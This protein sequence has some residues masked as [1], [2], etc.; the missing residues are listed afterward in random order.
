MPKTI[1][2]PF[3]DEGQLLDPNHWSEAEI[4]MLLR[5]VAAGQSYREISEAIS[6]EL[7]HRTE[8]ACKREF[9]RIRKKLVM[10]EL[11]SG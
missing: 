2:Y 11:E 7:N 5:G 10:K 6:K 1:Q 9:D 8:I 4:D 3:T